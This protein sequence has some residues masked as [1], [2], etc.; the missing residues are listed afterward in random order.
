MAIYVIVL[1]LPIVPDAQT[2]TLSPWRPWLVEE[3]RRGRIAAPILSP[4]GARDLLMSAWIVGAPLLI[5]AASLW[6]RYGHEVRMALWYLPPSLLFLILRWPFDGIGGGMD[7]V[8][9]GFPALYALAWVC[10]HDPKRANVAAMLLVS[11]HLAFWR[12]VFDER[13]E[14]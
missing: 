3:V 7:L 1:K 12:V 9:A 13:F 11:A 6:R 2:A 8:V 14:P 10:A 5:V 4:T